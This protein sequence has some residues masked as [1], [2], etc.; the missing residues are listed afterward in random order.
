M[1]GGRVSVSGIRIYPL[2]RARQ[3]PTSRKRCQ[4]PE[5]VRGV[6]SQSEIS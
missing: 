2:K 1:D 3:L 6:A 4:M 5:A